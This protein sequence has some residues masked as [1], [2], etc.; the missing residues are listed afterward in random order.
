LLAKFTFS[1]EEIVEHVDRRPY[2]NA[3]DLPVSSPAEPPT[4]AIKGDV[5]CAC[6]LSPVLA[7]EGNKTHQC[8]F[9]FYFRLP[10]GAVG[11]EPT[12]V[13]YSQ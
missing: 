11:Y 6:T 12:T 10:H 4:N 3:P 1:I 7:V 9:V 2:A 8:N 5:L 13:A